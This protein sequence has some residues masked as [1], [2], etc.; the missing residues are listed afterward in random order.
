[1][2]KQTVSLFL[3]SDSCEESVCIKI[4]ASTGSKF[5]NKAPKVKN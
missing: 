2:F 1:M 5:I 4:D 3:T